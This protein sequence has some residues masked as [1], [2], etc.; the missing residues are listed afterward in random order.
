VAPVVASTDAAEPTGRQL[1]LGGLARVAVGR[2]DLVRG[3]ED[4]VAAIEMHQHPTTRSFEPHRD[5][6]CAV[7]V[8]F[9]PASSA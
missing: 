8:Y 7:P 4:R 5:L 6:F 1:L 2:R 3:H 9:G